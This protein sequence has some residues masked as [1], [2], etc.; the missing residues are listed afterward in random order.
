MVKLKALYDTKVH[1]NPEIFLK[2]LEKENIGSKINTISKKW[3][4]H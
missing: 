2:I 3:I 4:S 1:M